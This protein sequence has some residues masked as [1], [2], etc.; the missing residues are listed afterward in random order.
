MSN[1]TALEQC[2]KCQTP[3]VNA[4]GIGP[5]CPNPACDVIDNLLGVERQPL[6]AALT[7]KQRSIELAEFL[8]A[9][10][11]KEDPR[12]A[13]AASLLR[14]LQQ[15]YDWSQIPP[16]PDETPAVAS[17]GESIPEVVLSDEQA[18]RAYQLKAQWERPNQQLLIPITLTRYVVY[19]R[20]EFA[21]WKDQALRGAAETTAECAKCAEL[22][23]QIAGYK[24]NSEM[25]AGQVIELQ[26]Q[27]AAYSAVKSE[28]PHIMAAIERGDPK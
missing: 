14:D 6:K 26:K 11:F 9:D 24:L 7:S 23:R 8:E 13:E 20:D 27:L 16:P 17:N 3:T 2:Y 22:E 15:F 18:E 4:P 28:V 12:F 1:P 10:Y 21:Y 25:W 5:Y 19:L